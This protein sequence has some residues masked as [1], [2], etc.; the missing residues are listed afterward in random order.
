MLRA[1]EIPR[2]TPPR[3]S[4]PPAPAA[5][6]LAECPAIITPPIFRRHLL[7][8]SERTIRRM[9]A[10]GKLPEMDVKLTAKLRGWKRST[11]E[12]WLELQQ[13]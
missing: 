3:R 4:T 1:N 6:P 2:A 8:V 11:L 9:V 7:D 12:K 5:G 13:A 10:A